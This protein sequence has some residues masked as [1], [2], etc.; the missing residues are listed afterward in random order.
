MLGMG[1]HNDHYRP[2]DSNRAHIVPFHSQLRDWRKEI[3]AMLAKLKMKINIKMPDLALKPPS[4]RSLLLGRGLYAA[5]AHSQAN[6]TEAIS[7]KRL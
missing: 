7:S 5:G 3:N 1:G 4:G 6:E 2:L